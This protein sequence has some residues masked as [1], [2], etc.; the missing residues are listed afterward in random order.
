MG[1]GYSNIYLNKHRD[2]HRD[3][4]AEHKEFVVQVHFKDRLHPFTVFALRDS[5]LP[6]TTPDHVSVCARDVGHADRRGHWPASRFQIDGYNTPGLDVPHH[7]NIGNVQAEV[8]IKNQPTTW[9]YL[10]GVAEEN[11]DKPFDYAKSWLYPG[12]FEII[13]SSLEFTGFSHAE[14]AFLFNVTGDINECQMKFKQ[15]RQSIIN[16]VLIFS[17]TDKAVAR[18]EL[19]G[20]TLDE[21]QVKTGFSEEGDSIA[22]LQTVLENDQIISITFK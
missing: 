13:E 8:N 10:T 9:V 22:F 20:K 5:L 16:P 14:R 2:F 15:D 18:V 4:I 11:S 19:D 12:S 7:G 17:G 6:G 21:Q 3:F 1:E